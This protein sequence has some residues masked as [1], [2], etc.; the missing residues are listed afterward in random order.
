MVSGY[1]VRTR[2][3]IIGALVVN[4]DQILYSASLTDIALYDLNILICQHR[5]TAIKAP[6]ALPCPH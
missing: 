2:K 4:I 3:N 1:V 5:L 6:T